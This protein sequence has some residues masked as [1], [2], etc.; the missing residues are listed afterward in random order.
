MQTY[1]QYKRMYRELEK[2]IAIKHGPDESDKRA[3]RYYYQD[4]TSQTN[5][6]EQTQSREQADLRREHGQRTG[7]TGPVLQPRHTARQ[8]LEGNDDVERAGFDPEIQGDPHVIH[9][10]DSLDDTTDIMAIDV[11]ES[12]HSR[13]NGGRADSRADGVPDGVDG[14]ADEDPSYPDKLIVVSYEGV[15]DPQDPHNGF[16]LRQLFC[17]IMI[18]MVAFTVLWSSTIDTT[19]LITVRHI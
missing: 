4:G 19:G 10:T 18:L 6:D 14:V 13:A 3:R 16:F 1:L 11:E 12:A 9:S 7:I 2:Q 15:Q 17:R 8:H 5:A